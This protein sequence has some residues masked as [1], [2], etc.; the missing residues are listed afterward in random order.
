L[1]QDIDGEA[2]NDQ[3]GYSVSLSADGNRVAIGAPYNDGT[4][5]ATD[6]RGHV[7]I[8][9]LPAPTSSAP[10]SSSV[11]SSVP[12]MN[13]VAGRNITVDL[14]VTVDA[15][16]TLEVFGESAPTLENIVYPEYKMDV[17]A[18]YDISDDSGLIEFWEPS[19]A[20]GKIAV[21][22]AN[23]KQ[24]KAK[25]VAQE[26]QKVLVDRMDATLATPF[27]DAKYKINGIPITEYIKHRDFGRLA[28]ASHA[29]YIFGHQAATSAI[30]NDK[31]F[32]EN[33]L[34]INDKGQDQTS[35]LDRYNAWTKLT[36]I[37]TDVENWDSTESKTDANLALRLAK[38]IC[39]KLVTAYADDATNAD[40]G[41]IVAQVIGQDATRAM[42]QDNNQLAPDMRQKLRFYP[43]DKIVVSITLNKPDVILTNQGQLIKDDVLEGKLPASAETYALVITLA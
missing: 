3:S 21:A 35:P 40:L 23:E 13:G 17:K 11:S 24:A 16:G 5:N 28:L 1:G 4:G 2:A 15:N 8:Y 36:S 37:A 42:S 7:R 26:L 27:N 25:L 30:T 43:G 18:L 10:S 12:S 14:N 31:V 19:I 29:H 22:Y 20:L 39:T 6:N 32:I 41:K 34:S 33:M 38:L 9:E